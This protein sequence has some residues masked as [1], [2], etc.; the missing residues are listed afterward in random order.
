ME[1][2]D[3][4]RIAAASLDAHLAENVQVLH[5]TDVTTLADYFVLATG[6][7]TTQVRALGDHVEMALKNEGITPLRMD[8][9][10]GTSWVVFDYGTVIVHIFTQQTRDFYGLERL[11]Q[12]A[13]PVALSELG[14][15][16]L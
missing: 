2:L 7:S 3:I 4:T 6:N 11:W 9:H 1:A 15:T 13:V 8:G 12:D 16:T 5:V 14:I 10:A